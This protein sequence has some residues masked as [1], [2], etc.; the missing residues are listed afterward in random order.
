MTVRTEH[1]DEG[2]VVVVTIDRPKANAID[3]ATSRELGEV[4]AGVMADP[5]ARVA[6]ITG[7]GERFFCAGWDL[8]AAADGEAFDSDYGVGGFGGF[9]ELPD[10]SKPV[11]A[12][13]NG[14]AVGGGFEIAMAADL[15]V[16]A[17]HAQFFLPEAALGMLP[18]AGSVRLPRL[19][20]TPLANEVLFA[21]R[22]LGAAELRDLG[23]VNAVAPAERL[24][25]EALAL[26]GRVVAS[27]PLSVAAILAIRRDL[28]HASV[29]DAM[30]ALRDHPAYRAAID[31]Q[32]ASEGVQAHAERRAPVWR[33]R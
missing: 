9:A 7:A 28:G 5:V 6:V 20:P 12:A 15:I 24:L 21:G 22:R 32:D 8:G 27:A 31:S 4:F 19:L 25:D 17:E 3:A 23:L 1:H 16:A 11:I 10:R 30:R 26:A 2:R 33:G 29:P 18:D 14:M 13:V